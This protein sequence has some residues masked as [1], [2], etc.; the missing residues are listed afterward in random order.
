[1]INS[2]AL[3]QYRYNESQDANDTNSTD[4]YIYK[5]PANFFLTLQIRKVIRYLQRSG[6]DISLDDDKEIF[7]VVF[8]DSNRVEYERLKLSINS[9]FNLDWNYVDDSWQVDVVQ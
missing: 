5:T 1:M 3:N 6:V 2:S 4:I 7:W 9:V 8:P